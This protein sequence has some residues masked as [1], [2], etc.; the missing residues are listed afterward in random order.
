[1]RIARLT[2]AGTMLLAMTGC[3]NEAKSAD[4]SACDLAGLSNQA[5]VNADIE[6][7]IQELL[8]LEPIMKDIERESLRD[9]ASTSL[10]TARLA[11]ASDDFGTKS[12]LMITG[13]SDALDDECIRLGLI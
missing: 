8:R 6:T 12:T 7:A 1:M 2:L 4:R 13:S 11:D 3:A 5:L 9:A 10:A